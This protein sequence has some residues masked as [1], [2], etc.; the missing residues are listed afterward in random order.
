MNNDELLKAF[1]EPIEKCA[2]YTP[3]FGHGESV[4][5]DDFGR[6]YGNDKF[7]SLIGLNSPLVY[8]AHKAAG[9]LTSIYRQIGVGAER[10]IRKVAA[11]T[12][13]LTESQLDWSYTYRRSSGKDGVHKLDARIRSTDITGKARQRLV[14]WMQGAQK[15]I[16]SGQDGKFQADGVVLEIRQGYKSADSKRQ[17]ADLRFAA[18]AYQDGLLPVVLVMSDQIGDAIV[19]RY[20]RDGLLV[21]TGVTGNDPLL[22]SFALINDLFE[23][24]LL[25]FLESNQKVIQDQLHSSIGALLSPTTDKSKR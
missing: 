1:L 16:S 22:S 8:A 25:E 2:S 20:R 10:L 11:D 21:T 9:G 23:F 18:R 14:K 3:K 15:Q 24:D 5:L 13:G 4:S 6:M 12:L 19:E 7:Y 17:N